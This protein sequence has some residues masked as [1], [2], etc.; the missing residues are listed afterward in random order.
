MVIPPRT[1]LDLV[2][3][4]WD[5]NQTAPRTIAA[6]CSSVELH[7]LG[8]S[9]HLELALRVHHDK[10]DLFPFEILSNVQKKNV[11]DSYRIILYI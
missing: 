5:R 11:C 2:T 4:L 3:W 10:P 9:H 1:R 6:S 8:D 7:L